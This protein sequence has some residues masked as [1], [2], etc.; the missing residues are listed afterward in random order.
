VRTRPGRGLIT[1]ILAHFG[2]AAKIK[3]IGLD[4]MQEQRARRYSIEIKDDTGKT[5][6]FTAAVWT[7]DERR[8]AVGQIMRLAGPAGYGLL[9]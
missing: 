3:Q 1:P 9:Y 8:A 4:Q 2:M 7:D 6:I 5:V